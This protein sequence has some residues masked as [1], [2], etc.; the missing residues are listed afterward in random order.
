MMLTRPNTNDVVDL[1]PVIA[2]QR[3]RLMQHAAAWPLL[4]AVSRPHEFS[5]VKRAARP[6]LFTKF[7]DVKSGR[8]I[9][10]PERRQQLE[11][12]WNCGNS[13]TAIAK[14]LGCK[15]AVVS[16]ARARFGLTPRRKISG[17]PKMPDEPGHKDQAG[18]IYHLAPH[19]VLHREEL[20]AQTGH[21]SYRW[22]LVIIKELVDNAL[23]DAEQREGAPVIKGFSSSSCTT[24]SK[25]TTRK[26]APCWNST[27][28]RTRKPSRG[29]IARA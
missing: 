14:V 3:R 29:V 18:G 21:E 6:K 19:G 25:S 7:D 16:V 10:T 17:R 24:L 20:V 27:N 22:L 11:E 26:P 13:A 9:W 5:K 2:P 1:A 15:A 12:M 8:I 23:D 4:I 28:R